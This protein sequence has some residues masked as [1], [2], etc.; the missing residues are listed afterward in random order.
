MDRKDMLRVETYLRDTF[1]NE[2][3][4]LRPRANLKD[5]VEVY[6]GSDFLGVLSE[7]VED[8]ETSYQFNM[9]ILDIDLPEK[10]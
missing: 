9:A 3:I 5:S 2:A 4:N 8:G 6:L 1:R 10:K 7:D